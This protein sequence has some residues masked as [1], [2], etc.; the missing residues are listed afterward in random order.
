MIPCVPA[1]LSL[2][3]WPHALCI[4]ELEEHTPTQRRLGRGQQQARH[5]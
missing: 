5:T 1:Y 2:D 3:A 4:G